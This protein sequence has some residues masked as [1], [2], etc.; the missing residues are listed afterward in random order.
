VVVA[1]GATTLLGGHFL[2]SALHVGPMNPVQMRTQAYTQAWLLPY[3]EQ[4]WTLFA[5][6]P[7][8]EDRGMLARFRCQDGTITDW[9]DVTTK[10]V[11]A[12]QRTRFFPP[13]NSRLVS[14]GSTLLTTNDP[15]AERLRDR[16]VSLEEGGDR[17]GGEDG[18]AVPLTSIEV[19]V[20]EMGLRFLSGYAL[21]E[22]PEACSGSVGAVQLRMVQHLFP[23]FSQRR[24]WAEPGEVNETDFSWVPIDD[25]TGSS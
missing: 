6:D 18:A 14:N 15:L 2:A 8:S 25:L 5:P 16:D 17:A 21:E 10:H 19:D 1:L 11:T 20:R 12:V 23:P 13:R 22:V 3:F 4:T 9:S 24:D 7:I